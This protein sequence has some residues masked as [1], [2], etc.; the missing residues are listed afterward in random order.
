M[1]FLAGFLAY[2]FI[3]LMLL[4][5]VASWIG[6]LAVIGITFAGFLL[7]MIVIRDASVNASQLMS[8]ANAGEQIESRRLGDAGLKFLA[9]V[10]IMVPG[11]LTDIVGLL[12]LIPFVRRLAR[13]LGIAAFARWATRR[14]MSVVTTNVD[15]VTVT[16][17]VPG[18][19]VAG[20]VIR[21]SEPGSNPEP[22][23]RQLDP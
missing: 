20:D 14:N 5:L 8:R 19:V 15:G 12:L 18:D 1:R 11:L 3:E 7:G 4:V 10:L 23:Y 6:W 9:G 21:R 22:P 16:R 2:V 13:G 17:M